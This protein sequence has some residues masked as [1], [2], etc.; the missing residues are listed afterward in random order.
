MT[1]REQV[2]I[3]TRQLIDWAVATDFDALPRSVASRAGRVIADNLAA[4]VA[5]RD[6]PEVAAFHRL[7]MQRAGA[8]EATIF[9]GGRPRTDRVSAAVSNALAADWLELEEG[10]RKAS[11]HAGLFIL[12]ALL[13]EAEAACLSMK[14]VLRAVVVAYEVVTRVARAWP[15]PHH[16]IHGHARYAALGAATATALAQRLPAQIMQGALT[17]AATFAVAGPHQHGIDGA[18]IRNA[19]P[20]AGTWSGIMSATWAGCGITGLPGGFHDVFTTVLGGAAQPDVLIDRLGEDWAILDGYSKMHACCQFAHSTVEAVLAARSP[21]QSDGGWERVDEIVVA[22]HA[23]ARPMINYRPQTTLAGKFSLPHIAATTWVHGHANVAAFAHDS[24]HDP[25]VAGLREKVRVVPFLPELPPPE[26]RPARV[27]VRFKDGTVSEGVCLSAPGGPDRPFSEAAVNEKIRL[28]TQDV[29]PHF[30]A[31]A[32]QWMALAPH[33]L[34]QDW[35]T[36]VGQL[37]AAP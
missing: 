6:E 29:Y 1:P 16:P 27:S 8:A 36:I 34:E 28:L 11:C 21:A 12:P 13:A 35:S 32:Q 15:L 10:Y 14:A 3:C 4:I 22:T 18:L 33:R 5:A 30:S 25:R 17:A 19:W 7:S 26:D 31:L 20:A 9:R 2:A 23:L 37:C 24:L